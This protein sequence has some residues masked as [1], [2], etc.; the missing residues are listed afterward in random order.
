MKGI[1]SL[2]KK[3]YNKGITLIA[4]VIT[5]IV[6]LIL[7]GISIATLTGENGILTRAD[8][9]RNETKRQETIEDAKLDIL[10]YETEN[11]GKITHAKAK[12]IIAKYDKDYSE[13][14]EFQF[15]TNESG[16]NYITTSDGYNILINEIWKFP[17]GYSFYR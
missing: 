14:E 4:L 3:E 17:R 1:T 8:N 9:A 11:E 5:I 7:A 15:K 12:E 6:L 10:A 16:D 2:K 13:G